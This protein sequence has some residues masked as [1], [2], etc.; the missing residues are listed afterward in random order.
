MQAF[1]CYVKILGILSIYNYFIFAHF[2][3]PKSLNYRKKVLS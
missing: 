3:G 2:L 1:T